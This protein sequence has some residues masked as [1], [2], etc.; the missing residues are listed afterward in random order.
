[1]TIAKMMKFLTQVRD[2]KKLS[3]LVCINTEFLI[4]IEEYYDLAIYLIKIIIKILIKEKNILYL[5]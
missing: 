1:M 4:I 2:Q 3:E 5:I